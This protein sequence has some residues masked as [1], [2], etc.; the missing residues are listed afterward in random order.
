MC[1]DGSCPV[2]EFWRQS[3]TA[4]STVGLFPLNTTASCLSQPPLPA[5]ASPWLKRMGWPRG[6]F[7]LLRHV[8]EGLLKIAQAFKP[9]TSVEKESRPVGTAENDRFYKVLSKN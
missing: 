8:P 9:G 2:P 1:R 6:S 5:G 4:G 7:S 3:L